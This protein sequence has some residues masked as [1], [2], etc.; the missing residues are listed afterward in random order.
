MSHPRSIPSRHGRVRG[1][2]RLL[3][4]TALAS[5]LGGCVA[6]SSNPVVSTSSAV[7]HEDRAVMTLL[8]RHPGGRDLVVT[9][10]GYELSHGEMALPV[11]EGHWEG[12]VD[13]P[14]GGEAS[15]PLDMPFTI[16]PLEPDARRLHLNGS[17]HLEDRTGFLG[18]RFMD[19]TDTA[20][21]IDVEA[22]VAEPS[23]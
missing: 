9:G 18:L 19:L 11:A 3:T 8:I 14:A 4:A 7:L 17:L 13:L 10:I 23:S 2:S 5:G 22:D 1:A 15:I 12:D 20:F 16:E 21:Q 6:D